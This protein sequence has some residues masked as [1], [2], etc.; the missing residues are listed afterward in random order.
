[1]KGDTKM[2]EVLQFIFSDA[3]HFLGSIVMLIIVTMWQPI[4]I[5]IL[6]GGIKHDDNK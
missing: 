1:M 6:N 2:V 5:T 4:D 3:W